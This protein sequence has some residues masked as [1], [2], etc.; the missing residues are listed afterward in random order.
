[1]HRLLGLESAPSYSRRVSICVS[2]FISMLYAACLFTPGYSS[3]FAPAIYDLKRVP[4]T[5]FC[6]SF[7]R[8]RLSLILKSSLITFPPSR[9]SHHD[10]SDHHHLYFV[11]VVRKFLHSITAVKS[12]NVASIFGFYWIIIQHIWKMSVVLLLPVRFPACIYADI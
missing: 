11:L 5:F 4:N 6:R 3:V 7:P 9:Q 10:H 1:M 2:L 8:S 12:S